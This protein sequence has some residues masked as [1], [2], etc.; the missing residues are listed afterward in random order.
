M[1]SRLKVFGL[2]ALLGFVAG[3]IA[4]VTAVFV[5]P[6]MVS[7]LPLLGGMT[8]FM[9]SG[10]AGACLTVVVVGAWAYMTGKKE[11]Y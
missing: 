3:I 10:F 6:W 4:Q 8:S 11:P 2:I 9:I 7:V 1:N 5:I